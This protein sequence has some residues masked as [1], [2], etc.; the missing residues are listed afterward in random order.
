MKKKNS[1][2]NYSISTTD[3]I[4]ERTIDENFSLSDLKFGLCQYWAIRFLCSPYE[5]IHCLDPEY[6]NFNVR[7]L[8]FW[9]W[10]WILPKESRSIL[11]FFPPNGSDSGSG[12]L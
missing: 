10:K 12:I 6:T 4:E 5:R 7:H 11:N 3:D 2:V 1:K 8:F 9:I